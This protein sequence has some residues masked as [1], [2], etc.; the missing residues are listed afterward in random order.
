MRCSGLVAEASVGDVFAPEDT[1]LHSAMAMSHEYVASR[2]GAGATSYC[3]EGDRGHFEC[4]QRSCVASDYFLCVA[5]AIAL[6]SS[7]NGWAAPRNHVEQSMR[8]IVRH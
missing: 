5:A 2:R 4:D 1:V 7:V 3:K 6:S 8:A